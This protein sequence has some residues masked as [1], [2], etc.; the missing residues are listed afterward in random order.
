M[1]IKDWMPEFPIASEEDNNLLNYFVKTDIITQLDNGEKWLVLGRKGTG[2]TA[3]FKYFSSPLFLTNKKIS[4]PLNFRD[5]PWPV[6]KLYK[7]S[8]EGEITAYFRSWKYIIIVQALIK[9]IQEKEKEGD[10]N[11][12]L[13]IAKK[14]ITKLY[15][16]PIPGLLE[17]IKSK[18]SRNK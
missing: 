5:Y 17:V 10:L 6:H 13:K 18:F 2:K 3:I 15:G 14:I 12:R 9:L 7:E 4:Q 1:D 11:R 16:S 8:M